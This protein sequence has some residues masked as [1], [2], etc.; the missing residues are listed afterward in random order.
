MSMVKLGYQFDWTYNSTQQK[1][2]NDSREGSL[3]WGKVGGHTCNG[4]STSMHGSRSEGQLC[5]GLICLYISVGNP[6]THF[7]VHSPVFKPN[8][9]ILESICPVLRPTYPILESIQPVLEVIHHSKN[10]STQLSS[11]SPAASA[12]TAVTILQE[13]QNTASSAFQHGLKTSY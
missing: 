7:Q 5:F 9:P 3:Q 6:S 11:P 10:P 13:H 2:S 4:G 1:G 12:L 8:Y